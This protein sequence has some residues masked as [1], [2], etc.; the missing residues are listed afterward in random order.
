MLQSS[1][2][3]GC[4]L[5]SKFCYV[6]KDLWLSSS[7]WGCELKMSTS[8]FYLCAVECHPP[9]EDVSWKAD[10][11]ELLEGAAASSSLWGC[12]LKRILTMWKRHSLPVILLVRMWVEKRRTFRSSLWTWSSSLWGCELKKHLYR[13]HNSST[14]SSSLWGCELKI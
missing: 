4:E 10:E 2:L 3:W 11:T 14:L 5:K 6:W 9:C 1:S 13:S 8:H 12:E 7:L